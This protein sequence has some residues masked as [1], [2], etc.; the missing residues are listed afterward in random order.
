MSCL[1]KSIS[2]AHDNALSVTLHT[3]LQA[4][5]ADPI[6][7]RR[8]DPWDYVAVPMCVYGEHEPNGIPMT[9]QSFF[10]GRQPD[11]EGG[12]RITFLVGQYGTGKTATIRQLI[13]MVQQDGG[14]LLPVGLGLIRPEEP[15]WQAAISA[16]PASFEQRLFDRFV[17]EGGDAASIRLALQEK[18]YSGDILLALD[19]LDEIV[20]GV[21]DCKVILQALVQFLLK[22][23]PGWLRPHFDV[24]VSVRSE[25]LCNIGLATVEAL[26]EALVEAGMNT[27]DFPAVY[28]VRLDHLGE[29]KVKQYLERREHAHYRSQLEKN[30]KLMKLLQRPLLLKLFCDYLDQVGEKSH[31][32]AELETPVEVLSAF[33]RSHRSDEIQVSKGGGSLKFTWDYDKL[34][35]TA[36]EIYEKAGGLGY[37]F[38]LD[39]VQDA[40][41]VDPPASDAPPKDFL[42]RVC[43]LIVHKCAF[44]II[45]DDKF[46]AFSHR[47][48]YEYFVANGILIQMQPYAEQVRTFDRFDELILN[49]DMRKFLKDLVEKRHKNNPHYSDWQTRTRVSY[50]LGEAHLSQWGEFGRHLT[51]GGPDWRRLENLRWR[52]LQ[53]MTAPE[54]ESNDGEQLLR[55]AMAEE[56]GALHPR[57]RMYNLEAIAVYLLH[58]PGKAYVSDCWERFSKLLE[59]RLIVTVT[60][61]GAGK[62]EHKASLSLLLEKCIDIA[63]RLRFPWIRSWSE[64]EARKILERNAK[65]WERTRKQFSVIGKLSF[66]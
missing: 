55:D 27:A 4:F 6:K 18:I 11:T 60:E 62:E 9:M 48:F 51:Y 30:Q 34:A 61:L 44:I 40:V 5:Q 13:P 25:F 36:M 47:I 38:R 1:T 35:E 12:A 28:L 10:I 29:P 32:P 63:R 37:E 52:L 59:K 31:E 21:E 57:Y 56:E 20:T 26:R 22:A 43:P 8:A 49:V 16:D 64:G 41:S 66:S 7:S 65:V 45:L 15:T 39:R 2:N 19:G 17:P 58:W 14:A 3:A 53:V 50:A 33:L 54:V 46:C 23:P 42:A 24:I